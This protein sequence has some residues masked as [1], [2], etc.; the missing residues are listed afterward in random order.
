MAAVSGV[1]EALS[2]AGEQVVILEMVAMV[3]SPR[4]TMA[5]RVLVAV[6]AGALMALPLVILVAQAAVA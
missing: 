6:A 3:A 5:L 1:A 4:L 2:L